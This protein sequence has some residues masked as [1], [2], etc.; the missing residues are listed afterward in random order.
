MNNVLEIQENPLRYL[1][2]ALETK[3]IIVG[4][5]NEDGHYVTYIGSDLI[6]PELIYLLHLFRQRCDHLFDT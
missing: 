1:Q 6:E 3:S 4:Y 5:I 2:N